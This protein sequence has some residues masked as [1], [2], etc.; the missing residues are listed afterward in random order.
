M[1]SAYV[2]LVIMAVLAFKVAGGSLQNLHSIFVRKQRS[3]LRNDDISVVSP[4]T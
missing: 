2:V 4:T 3:H 1:L